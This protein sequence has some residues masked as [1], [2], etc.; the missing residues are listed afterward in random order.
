M[1]FLHL[2]EDAA[3]VSHFADGQIAMAESVFAALAPAMLLSPGEAAR[4][5]VF[6][7]LPAGWHSPRH[8]SPARQVALLLAG[9]MRI[10]AGDGEVREIGPGAIWR[11]EDVAG[12]GHL[13]AVLGADNVQI[14]LVQV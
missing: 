9:R 10:E 2:T 11:M 5:L 7:T 3:G 13:S 1:R 4:A 8:P 14:A 6:L 12:S